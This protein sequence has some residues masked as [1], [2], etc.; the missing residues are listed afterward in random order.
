VMSSVQDKHAGLA[1]GIN[2]AV[3]RTAGLLAI[4]VMGPLMIVIFNNILLQS[5]TSLDIPAETIQLALNEIST[6]MT[7]S[8]LAKTISQDV[9]VQLREITA[10]SFVQGFRIIIIASA[11]CALTASL[12]AWKFVDRQSRPVSS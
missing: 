1:S 2:N 11:L 4:A 3:S 8:K 10:Q 12:I 6:K 5:I 7:G 9:V